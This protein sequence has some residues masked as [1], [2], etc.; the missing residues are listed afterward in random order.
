MDNTGELWVLEIYDH[1][2]CW[3]IT[4]CEPTSYI[5][6]IKDNVNEWFKVH[7]KDDTCKYRI[8]QYKQWYEEE[9]K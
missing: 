6:Q 1:E 3:Q 2:E 8:V 9:V 5:E 4:T 7:P